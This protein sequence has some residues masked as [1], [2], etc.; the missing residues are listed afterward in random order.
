M[1][2]FICFAT[3]ATGSKVKLT[4]EDYNK[5]LEAD[6]DTFLEVSGK[7]FKKSAVME[8]EDISAWKDEAPY[9]YGQPYAALPPGIGFEG[10]ITRE[11]RLGALEGMARGL[12][13]AKAKFNRPTPQIDSLLEL[14]RK[15][16]KFVK[17][18]A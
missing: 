12:K 2:K 16:Y 13:K 4:Q 8:V 10:M 17:E 11:K 7:T 5:F 18:K 3:L 15:R 6:N 9:S 14:A 1:D